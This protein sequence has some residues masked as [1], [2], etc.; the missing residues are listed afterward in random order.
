MT[1]PG[2]LA[3][4]VM[5]MWLLQIAISPAGAAEPKAALA[6]SRIASHIDAIKS[7]LVMSGAPEAAKVTL[8]NPD[9]VIALEEGQPLA[10]DSVSFNPAT[11]RFLLR[12]ATAAGAA[13]LAI[14]GTAI[15]AIIL[16][17]PARAMAR[18]ELVSEQDLQWVE[19]AGA[20]AGLYLDDA[21]AII[22]KI[23]R[24]PLTPGAPLR[25][26]DLQA[27][28][29]IKRG[30]TATIVL[31]APGIRLTQIGTALANGGAG[32]LIAF[33]N[34]NSGR[35]IKAVVTGEDLASAPFRSASLAALEQD[36]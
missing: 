5:A 7:A 21:D 8:N 29:L 17:V 34:I 19:V 18:G 32:D 33:R 22:G 35:E 15:A 14:T 12:A 23:A 4:S 20:R 2:I 30:S 28:T 27:P 25:N 6:Q 24:R 3:Y 1:V 9:A 10:F 16:P 31:Q 26:A 13:P 11:G 36:Q